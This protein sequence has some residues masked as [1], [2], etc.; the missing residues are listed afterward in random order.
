MW[1]YGWLSKIPPFSQL[2][3]DHEQ[4]LGLGLLTLVLALLGLWRARKKTLPWIVF[5][6]V[7]SVVAL[8]S[9]G[10]TGH[11]LWSYV[12]L[13]LPGAAAIRAVSRISLVLLIAWS[14]GLALFFDRALIA[15]KPKKKIMLGFVLAALC[16]F[17]QG[18][19]LYTYNKYDLQRQ[20][21]ILTDGLATSNSCESFYYSSWRGKRGPWKYQLDAMWASMNSGIPTIN[22]YSGNLPPRWQ[23]EDNRFSTS[24]DLLRIGKALQQWAIDTKLPI[25]RT[26]WLRRY[27]KENKSYIF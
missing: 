4:Q 19:L 20:G 10:P 13:H 2:V 17:E 25:E 6:T 5:L 23:L 12:Y 27:R 24:H 18:R 8:T 21:K 14:I 9:V 26:C 1:L 22:G 11:S 16:V 15:N 3:L 7:I